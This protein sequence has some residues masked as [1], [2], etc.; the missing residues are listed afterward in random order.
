MKPHRLSP[1]VLHNGLALGF[2]GEASDDFIKQIEEQF[3]V[4]VPRLKITDINHKINE[5]TV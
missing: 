1:D 4:K 2:C 5:K 3:Q